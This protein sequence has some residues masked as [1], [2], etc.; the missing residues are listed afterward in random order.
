MPKKK[1]KR[2]AI[3]IRVMPDQ[4]KLI[5]ADIIRIASRSGLPPLSVSKYAE[6]AVIE[7]ERLSRVMGVLAGKPAQ[8]ADSKAVG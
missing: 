5:R 2:H 7:Y 4:M 1:P 3:T 8:D 6:H